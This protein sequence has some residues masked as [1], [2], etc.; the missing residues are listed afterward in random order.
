MKSLAY[1]FVWWPKLDT[2]I[3]SVV[4]SCST[5][6]VLGAD[7]ILTVLLLWYRIHVDYSG[8]LYSKMYI[9]LI[10]ANSKWMNVHITSGCTTASTI[11]KL[12]L[13][14][15]TF[16]LPQVL[17]SDNGPALSITEFQH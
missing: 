10:H 11:E 1:Q 3:A 14:F 16:G 13:S 7:P 5:C 9:I 4:H 15:S 6:T 8:L 17:V 2:D 12:Q